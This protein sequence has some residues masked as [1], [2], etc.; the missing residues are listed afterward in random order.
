M[1]YLMMIAVALVYF[2]PAQAHAESAADQISAIHKMEDGTL[3]RL[4]KEKPDTRRE[5]N[6]AVGYAVFDSGELAVVWVSAGY[7]HGVAHSNQ[8][9]KDTYMKMAK[10]G[11][12]LGIGVKDFNTVFVFHEQKAFHDF[13]TTG[14]DLS[15]TAD[16]AAKAGSN[17]GAV[18]GGAD[19]LPGVSVYQLTDDG[20]L[21]QAMVQGTKYWRD[22]T[23]NGAKMSEAQ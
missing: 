22:D 9:A 11:V 4:Y 21:A 7:G 15:G 17:G 18:S 23:L 2:V 19:V 16:V 8:N 12:G 1:K 10:A 5:I 3:A 6:E 20:L 14:L 13:T